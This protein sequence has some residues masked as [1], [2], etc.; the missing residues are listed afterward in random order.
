MEKI[1]RT[2]PYFWE[3]PS[4]H[5]IPPKLTIDMIVTTERE[6]GLRLP[7]SYLAVLMM[8]NGGVTRY[9]GYVQE[10]GFLESCVW[11]GCMWVTH[12]FVAVLLFIVLVFVVPQFVV[13]LENFDAELPAAPKTSRI[14]G[15]PPMILQDSSH[16][17]GDSSA[18]G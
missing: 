5:N 7:D 17:I 18:S 13:V 3:A 8:Q 16:W 10:N 6:L 12:A 11:P 9:A 4:R 14:I 1:D 15:S 2:K